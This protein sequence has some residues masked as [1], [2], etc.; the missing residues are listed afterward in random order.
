[1]NNIS[2][3]N[4]N[5]LFPFTISATIFAY[6]SKYGSTFTEL[7]IWNILCTHSSNWKLEYSNTQNITNYRLNLYHSFII[8]LDANI[9]FSF[10]SF[11]FHRKSCFALPQGKNEGNRENDLKYET[12]RP[13][14][15]SKLN[16]KFLYSVQSLLDSQMNALTSFFTKD[17]LIF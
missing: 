4:L 6:A 14:S 1:M 16:K 11:F 10:L 5:T 15:I 7:L 17:G 2:L 9:V 3:W 13:L 8:P 12:F